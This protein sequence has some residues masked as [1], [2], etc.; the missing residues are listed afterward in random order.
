[1][2]LSVSLSLSS[3]LKSLL[4][5]SGTR[6][7]LQNVCGSPHVFAVLF[8]WGKK[9][10]QDTPNYKFSSFVVHFL[11][12]HP[13]YYTCNSSPQ[14]ALVTRCMLPSI[15]SS[16]L[17]LISTQ[18]QICLCTLIRCCF[19]FLFLPLLTLLCDWMLFAPKAM[20]YRDYS[21]WR[22]YLYK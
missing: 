20:D 14:A 16:Y 4:N 12:L 2:F 13:Q 10:L 17:F 5:I 21:M 22:S 18:M 9:N 11:L 3:L 8:H 6:N 15:F 1:M 7:E 19:F